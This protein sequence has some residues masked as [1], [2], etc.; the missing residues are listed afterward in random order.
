MKNLQD[1]IETFINHMNHGR[2]DNGIPTGLIHITS[3]SKDGQVCGEI[4]RNLH[5]TLSEGLDDPM[6]LIQTQADT[7]REDMIEDY[8]QRAFTDA[9]EQGLQSVL[10]LITGFNAIDTEFSYYS[11]VAENHGL[12]LYYSLQLVDCGATDIISHTLDIDS[13]ILGTCDNIEIIRLNHVVSS[14][15]YTM[16]TPHLMKDKNWFGIA[17]KIMSLM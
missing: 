5:K 12:E 15:L 17:G 13:T 16:I 7:T 10:L 8:V 9:Y 3:S 1:K 11:E 6:P 2:I 4:I 14:I